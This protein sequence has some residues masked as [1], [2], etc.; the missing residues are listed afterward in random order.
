MASDV[1]DIRDP[2]ELQVYGKESQASTIHIASY[3][4]E[5]RKFLH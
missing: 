2:D 1:S 4:F 5:V 3:L